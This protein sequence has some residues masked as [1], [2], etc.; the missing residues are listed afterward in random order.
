[1][2]SAIDTN[3]LNDI[4]VLQK[5]QVK[6]PNDELGQDAFLQLVVAQLKNQDPLKPMENGEFLSQ[7]AQFQ[8]VTGID[9]LKKSVD[10]MATAMQSNQALQASSLVGRWVVV[11][12]DKSFLWEDANMAGSVE[13]PNRADNVQVQIKNSSGATV[14]QLDLGDQSAGTANFQW[15]GLGDDGVEYGAGEY[16]ISSF[17]T[18]AGEV[19]ALET[20][21]I[22]PVDS[23][24]MGRAGESMTVNAAGVGNVKLSDVKQ[25]M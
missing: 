9:E 20:N 16:S 3:V 7:L 1:M 6:T 22:V 13:V 10:S 15:D 5:Q 11:S 25:I 23:V 18:I 24:L 4:G 8:S 2:T 12:S 19:E 14:K 21:A 17:G